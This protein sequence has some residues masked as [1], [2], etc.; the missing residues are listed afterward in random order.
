MEVGQKDGTPTSIVGDFR[1]TY[2]P[3]PVVARE[4]RRDEDKPGRGQ[5]PPGSTGVE[6]LESK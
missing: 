2:E 3:Q 4:D 6:I 1:P 5:D